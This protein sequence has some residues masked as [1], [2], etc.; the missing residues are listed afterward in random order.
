MN[1]RF[2]LLLACAW[3]GACGLRPVYSGGSHGVVA[4]TLRTIQV[5]PIE[6]QAGWLIRNKL[7]DRLLW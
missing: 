1:G 3:L 4:E 5:G 7:T 2:L 6:G